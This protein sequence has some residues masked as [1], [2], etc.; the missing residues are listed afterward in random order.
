MDETGLA[1]LQRCVPSRAPVLQI[2]GRLADSGTESLFRYRMGLLGIT[3]KSQV[4][5]DGVGVVD[6]VIGDR[7]VVE[8][9]SH[10]HHGTGDARVRDL[11]R[12]AILA[13]LGYL[14]LRFDYWMIIDDWDL[15]ASTVFAVVARGDHLRPQSR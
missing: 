8:I 4:P 14:S 12:D 5:I 11:T 9:D 1:H 3:M 10:A 15:V 7:L 2:A 6:F 13:G